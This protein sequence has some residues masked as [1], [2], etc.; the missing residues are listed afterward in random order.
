MEEER[1]S[2]TN[3]KT[4]LAVSVGV[5]VPPHYVD[6]GDRQT[7]SHTGQHRQSKHGVHSVHRVEASDTEVG[8]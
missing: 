6:H 5:L 7:N 2:C 1:R 8:H 3:K 4:D